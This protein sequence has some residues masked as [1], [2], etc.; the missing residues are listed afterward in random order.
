MIKKI[1]KTEDGY[2]VVTN[3]GGSDHREYVFLA[4]VMCHNEN[5]VIGTDADGNVVRINMN[6]LEK[7]YY[8]KYSYAGK[9]REV[10]LCGEKCWHRTQYVDEEALY[11]VVFDYLE[12]CPEFS[13]IEELITYLIQKC[14][15][16]RPAAELAE[17]LKQVFY[18]EDYP[19][20]Y[21]EDANHF[22]SRFV[23]VLE[24][25]KIII[26]NTFV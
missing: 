7:E 6:T 19:H 18:N 8:K 4:N 16:T 24:L 1:L 12:G 20:A 26:T 25:V 11:D 22:S 21:E 10:K 9:Y 17:Q 23:V 2:N 13:T 5:E 15:E 14:I 3:N